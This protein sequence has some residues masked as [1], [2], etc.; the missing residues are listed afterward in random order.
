[1][2]LEAHEK[3]ATR[4]FNELFASPFAVSDAGVYAHHLIE[5]NFK[6]SQISSDNRGLDTLLNLVRAFQIACNASIKQLNESSASSTFKKGNAWTNW[7]SR[8]MEILEAE[9]PVTVHKDIGNKSRD[10]QS[11]FTLLVWELQLCLPI[12]C[13]RHPHSVA[14]LADAISEARQIGDLAKA[15]RN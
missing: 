11:P 14:A 8:L 5:K 15:E 4:F 12:E 2:I 7:I 9:L 10:K 1:V 6:A 13:R 3:A